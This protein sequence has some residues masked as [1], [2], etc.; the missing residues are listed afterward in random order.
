MHPAATQAG[1]LI[2]DFLARENMTRSQLASKLNF[3][4]GYLSMLIRGERPISAHVAQELARAT[5]IPVDRWQQDRHTRGSTPLATGTILADW[6]IEK[7][8][9][10]RLLN[11]SPFRTDGEDNRLQAASYDLSRGEFKKRPNDEWSN[12][13]QLVLRPGCSALVRTVEEISVT[14][15][16]VAHIAP[17]GEL[18]LAFVMLSFGLHLDPGWSGHPYMHLH[19]HGDEEFVLDYDQRFA[20]IEFHLLADDPNSVWAP[21]ERSASRN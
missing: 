3:S 2:E 7:A 18:V 6:R 14:K 4:A 12:A 5:K 15:K 20:S 21:P 10:E 1:R 16:L 11:I 13:K 19:N 17:Q 9:R 8:I